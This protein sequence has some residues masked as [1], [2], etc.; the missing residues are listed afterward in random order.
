MLHRNRR[1]TLKNRRKTR[2]IFVLSD[3]HSP[4]RFADLSRPGVHVMS[5]RVPVLHSRTSARSEIRRIVNE[6]TDRSAARSR[7]R[8]NPRGKL[9]SGIHRGPRDDGTAEDCVSKKHALANRPSL[10]HYGNRT[11]PG[12]FHFLHST[13]DV[14][15]MQRLKNRETLRGRETPACFQRCS[16]EPL[17]PYNNV[18]ATTSFPRSCPPRFIVS[19]YG[20]S[21]AELTNVRARNDRIY[22]SRRETRARS[23]SATI[24]S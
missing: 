3:V 13:L 5:C 21:F 2:N 7:E 8:D 19:N 20:D 9:N 23:P 6:A 12:T 15:I 24:P 17:R 14:A 10:R 18:R 16:R 1:R 11:L 22:R 4:T